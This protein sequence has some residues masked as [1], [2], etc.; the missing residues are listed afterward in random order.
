M[1]AC[2]RNHLHGFMISGVFL[3]FHMF[4]HLSA[5]VERMSNIGFYLFY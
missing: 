4:M 2:L 5:Y 1:A 3:A